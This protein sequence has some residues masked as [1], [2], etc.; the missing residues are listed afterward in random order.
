M[1]EKEAYYKYSGYGTCNICGKR[2]DLYEH[3]ILK[4]VV[5]GKNDEIGF[6]CESCHHHI[7]MSIKLFEEAILDKFGE[8]NIKIWD[9]YLHKGGISERIIKQ[10]ARKR[11][12]ELTNKEIFYNKRKPDAREGKAEYYSLNNKQLAEIHSKKCKICGKKVTLTI[13]HI[14]KWIV[15]KDN[16]LLGFPCRKCHGA[17]EESVKIHEKEV[18][19]FFC[20][21]YYLIWEVCCKDGF[22]PSKRVRNLAKHRL[23]KTRDR[24]FGKRYSEKVIIKNY[25]KRENEQIGR[26]LRGSERIPV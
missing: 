13:H 19:K 5:F 14:K 1:I 15:F 17:I 21:S 18:L 23:L 4:E 3:H 16:S 7:D 6:V 24:F 10:N 12:R 20:D 11:F 9:A 22:I 2:R 8:C 26:I 25:E